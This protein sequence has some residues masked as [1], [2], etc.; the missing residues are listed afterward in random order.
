MVELTVLGISLQGEGGA[1][2]LLLHPQ[3]MDRILALSIGPMEAFA[4]SS[5]LNAPGQGWSGAAL[6]K[7]K[8]VSLDPEGRAEVSGGRQVFL[9]RGQQSRSLFPRPQTH[10]LTL[11][12]LQTL[13]AQL[14]GV[15]IL[16]MVDGVF[17]A[18]AVL[19]TGSTIIRVDCRPSDGV[20]LAIRC[21][22]ML[23]A[24]RTVL[25]YAEDMEEILGALPEH[26]RLLARSRMVYSPS[27]LQRIRRQATGKGA[28][29]SVRQQEIS[30]AVEAALAVSDKFRGKEV[31]SPWTE[32]FLDK[33]LFLE[34]PGDAGAYLEIRPEDLTKLLLEAAKPE[35]LEKPV[36]DGKEELAL[37][38]EM[39][40]EAADIR[41]AARALKKQAEFSQ[42]RGKGAAGSGPSVR[43]SLVK[44]K[45]DGQVE[46][47][48]AAEITAKPAS[49]GD[50]ILR[51]RAD[52]EKAAFAE[53]DEDERWAALLKVLTPETKAI[54]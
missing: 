50:V 44:Q 9:H 38:E 10:D 27:A 43:I 40:A 29:A 30:P 3:G 19:S 41:A 33:E 28:P 48:D 20:A 7:E 52:A 21:G 15:E 54:M 13:G 45:K 53:L 4:I 32:T 36:Q 17:I 49:G 2:V 51:M 11:Q 34:E 1:P 23:R 46:V 14:L 26:V 16:R 18:E 12:L 22:A 39:E 47:L 6:I 35:V 37:L 5:V 31:K 8:A 24:T 25:S 42:A